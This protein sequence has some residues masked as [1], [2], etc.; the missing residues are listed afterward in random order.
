M[1][2]MKEDGVGKSWAKLFAI[3]LQLETEDGTTVNLVGIRN[4]GE[5]VLRVRVSGKED[6]QCLSLNPKTR[7]VKNFRIEKKAG[8]CPWVLL[9]RALSFLPN[10]M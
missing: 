1:W 3:W 9:Q 6:D 7:Q 2:L 8:T 10:P 4:S 5:L